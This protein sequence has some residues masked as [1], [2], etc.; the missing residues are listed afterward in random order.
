[1]TLTDFIEIRGFLGLLVGA[2][3]ERQ[4]KRERTAFALVAFDLQAATMPVDDVLDDGQTQ[5]G[6]AE[7]A[8]PGLVNSV[9]PLCQPGNLI[10]R[11]PFA[12]ILNGNGNTAAADLRDTLD[13]LDSHVNFRIMAAIFNRVIN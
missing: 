12:K 11:N 7:T 9:K 5:A 4:R 2:F 13:G 8:R 10:L 1:M 3:I 6:T